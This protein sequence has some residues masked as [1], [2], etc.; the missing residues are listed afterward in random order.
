MATFNISKENWELQHRR[1]AWHVNITSAKL[2]E[3]A[4]D[5]ERWATESRNRS[6]CFTPRTLGPPKINCCLQCQV[7][8]PPTYTARTR[9]TR[10]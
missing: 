7:L 6:S 4:P 3:K 5:W 2:F 10:P 9:T 8:C 1:S